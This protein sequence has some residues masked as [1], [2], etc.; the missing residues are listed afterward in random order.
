MRKATIAAAACALIALAGCGTT[1]EQTAAYA[2]G[3]DGA[4]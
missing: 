2:L 1:A 4:L 3:E